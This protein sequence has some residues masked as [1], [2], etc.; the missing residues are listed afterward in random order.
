MDIKKNDIL[1]LDDNNEYVVVSK[2][3]YENINYLYIV[4]INNIQNL[5]FVKEGNDELLEIH[6]K[7]LISVLVPLFI[8]ET[9]AT[10][11]FN[12]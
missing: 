5:K 6:D 11:L 4:D 3:N 10:S 8:S 2:I 9:N 12:I 7:D 1:T